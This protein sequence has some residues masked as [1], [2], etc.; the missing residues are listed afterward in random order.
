MR[1]CG[2]C[3]RLVAQFGLVVCCCGC[4]WFGV[5][6]LGFL[7]ESWWRLVSGWLG[8]CRGLWVVGLISEVGLFRLLYVVVV[9]VIVQ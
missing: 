9:W 1:G 3:C 4:C 8:D 6:R 5:L 2:L 7:L